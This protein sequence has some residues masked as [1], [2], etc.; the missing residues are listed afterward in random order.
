MAS[1]EAKMLEHSRSSAVDEKHPSDAALTDRITDVFL[2]TETLRVLMI[3]RGVFSKADFDLRLED[4]QDL[5][6]TRRYF[7]KLRQR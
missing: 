5:W 6:A 3:H 4:I 2:R 7:L 1:N